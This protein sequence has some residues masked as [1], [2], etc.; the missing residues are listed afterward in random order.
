MVFV[1][2]TCDSSSNF[3]KRSWLVGGPDALEIVYTLADVALSYLIEAYPFFDARA[4]TVDV[5][6]V[7]MARSIRTIGIAPGSVDAVDEAAREI[8]RTQGDFDPG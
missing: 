1:A 2:M 8:F 7:S 5:G 6:D 3:R 4:D